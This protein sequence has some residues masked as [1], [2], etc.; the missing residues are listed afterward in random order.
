MDPVRVFLNLIVLSAVPPPE[1][2]SPCWW[3][4]HVI[5]LTAAVWSENF[6]MGSVLVVFHTN[7]LLSFPPEHNCCSSGDHLRP[8]TYCLWPNNFLMKGELT[9]ISLWRIVLSLDPVLKIDEFQA[10]DPTLFVWPCIILI[11]FILLTS[12][13]WTSPLF[14]PTEKFGPFIDQAT[15][16]TESERPRSQSLVTLDV[17]PFHK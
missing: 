2:R 8:Q 5:A 12:Q 17:L 11:L 1:T 15:D 3:G 14:V 9:R 10:I 7:S 16:V 4:D 13:I 6:R